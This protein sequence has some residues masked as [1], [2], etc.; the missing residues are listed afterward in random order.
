LAVPTE[1]GAVTE[2]TLLAGT[3]VAESWRATV[4]AGLEALRAAGV[5]P[6]LGTVLMSD[7]PGATAFMDRKHERCAEL[8]VPT[9]RVDLPADAPAERCYRAVERLADD[10]GVT[11]LFVQVP[12]PDHVDAG[13]VRARVPPA[14]DVDCFAPANLGR[15]VAGD[16]RVTP[17]TPAAVLRLLD[18]HDVAVAGQE[19]VVVGRTTAICRP[20]ASLLLAR[21]ATVTTCHTRTRDL[22]A[23]TR[24]ADLL[25]T[26]AG[27][28]G[29]VDGSML[30]P[31]VTVV[32]IS[33]NR[34]DADTERGHEV[35][36]DVAFESA[37]RKA[38][39]ITPVPGGVGPLTLVSLLSNVVDLTA[40]A[41]GVESALPE[42]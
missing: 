3:P 10:D 35:V 8:G 39:A 4:T 21:D 11:A 19:A 24:R 33:A 37:R 16:P 20:L 13:A 12:L 34:V 30:S 38:D 17:A 15:L 18:A 1:P 2:P 32:D 27:S 28:P 22:P 25:V 36:G 40:R 42:R 5:E 9:R 6:T 7:D 31:G 29:L 41:A 23:H 14:K 26:A